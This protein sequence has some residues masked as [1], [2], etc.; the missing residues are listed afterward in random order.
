MQIKHMAK[1]KTDSFRYTGLLDIIMLEESDVLV[2]SSYSTFSYA[3]HARGLA[4]PYYPS[5]RND[6]SS[7]CGTVTGTE[8]GLLIFDF[9]SFDWR[10]SEVWCQKVEPKCL[11]FVMS[12]EFI[13]QCLQNIAGR[14]GSNYSCQWPGAE[15][16]LLDINLI[17]KVTEYWLARFGFDLKPNVST[18]NS[19]K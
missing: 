3:A 17:I 6:R 12:S 11:Q 7:A 4:L 16:F 19:C 15:E 13:G 10:R 18:F 1:D 8:G 14:L 5:F 9:C 2:G